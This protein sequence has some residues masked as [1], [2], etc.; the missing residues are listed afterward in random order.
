[1][2]RAFLPRHPPPLVLNDRAKSKSS[3]H[4]LM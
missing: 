4:Y 2:P 3:P 1:V